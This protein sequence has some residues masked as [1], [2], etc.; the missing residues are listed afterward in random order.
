MASPYTD[1]LEKLAYQDIMDWLAEEP[2]ESER[3]D[4]KKD[5]SDNVIAA[6]VTMANHD[7]MTSEG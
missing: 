2:E 3:L 7:G 5:F 6:I 4:F 1:R